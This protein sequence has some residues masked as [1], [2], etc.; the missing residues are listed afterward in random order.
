[1]IIGTAQSTISQRDLS[2]GRCYKTYQGVIFKNVNGEQIE[3]K[4]FQFSVQVS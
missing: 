3:P 4:I 2:F 1:M